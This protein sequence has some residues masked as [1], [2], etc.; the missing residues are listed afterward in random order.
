[1]KTLEMKEMARI[2]GGSCGSGMLAVWS[3]GAVEYGALLG[4]WVGAVGV[5]AGGCIVGI[6]MEN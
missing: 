1:M 5:L 3:V 2:E 6:L 4:G